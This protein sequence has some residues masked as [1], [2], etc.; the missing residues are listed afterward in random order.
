[1]STITVERAAAPRTTD[2]AGAGA[3]A[4]ITRVLLGGVAFA[5]GLVGVA[6]LI[7]PRST[8]TFFSWGLAPAPLAAFVGACYVASALV[9]GWAAWVEPW[10]GQRGLCV[11]V[12][13]LAAPTLVATAHHR[14]V[15]D[16]GR[17][18]AIAWVVL[19]VASVFSFGTLD[20]RR[21]RDRS[22]SPFAFGPAARLILGAVSVVY[23]AAA[24]VLWAWPGT[25]S[26]Y[27]PITAGPLG[28][29]FVGSW[30]AFLA[31][32]A[33]YAATHPRLDEARLAVATLVVFPLATLFATVAHTEELRS[34][35]AAISVAALVALA[36]AG[37]SVL[38]GRPRLMVPP[39]RGGAVR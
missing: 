24:A 19:F 5:A 33:A 4:T 35:P 8:G 17:W 37:L 1:M 30:A 23:A 18:Q 25:V 21:R 9:F 14:D 29:R 6:M 36:V 27:G 32:T 11:A 13:G 39:T 2:T 20:L 22:T 26:D 38:S 28:L 10:V 3:V 7:A 16:F 31:L 15:F 12:L 34:R